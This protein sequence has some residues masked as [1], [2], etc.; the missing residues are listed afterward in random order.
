M[1]DPVAQQKLVV[2]GLRIEAAASRQKMSQTVKELVE[3][4][5]QHTAQDP[6]IVG[7]DKKS[8]HFI[9]KSSC[10]LL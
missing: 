9:E 5:R 10:E 2:E 3:F 1:S 7:I 4:V 8:N 6:L